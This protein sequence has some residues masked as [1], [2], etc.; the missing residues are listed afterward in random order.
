MMR[1][2]KLKRSAEDGY[3]LIEVMA[4]TV[5]MGVTFAYMMPIFLLSRV[6]IDAS[7][8]RSGAIIVAQRIVSDVG[9]RKISTL[10]SSGTVDITDTDTLTSAGRVYQAEVVYCPLI[11]GASGCRTNYRQVQINVTHK[12]APVF[13]TQTAVSETQ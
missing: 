8:R 7:A 5:I 11:S 2:R 3:T 1:L 13:S 10:P 4:A 12:N 9:S 6:K